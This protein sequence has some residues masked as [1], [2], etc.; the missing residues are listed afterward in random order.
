MNVLLIYTFLTTD[1][2]QGVYIKNLEGGSIMVNMEDFTPALMKPTVQ[3]NTEVIQ[4]I[5]SEAWQMVGS[6]RCWENTEE[7]Q[8]AQSW[9][10]TKFL[11]SND[12]KA[13][14]QKTFRS[15][16]TFACFL[17]METGEWIVAGL[18]KGREIHAKT[19]TAWLLMTEREKISNLEW[20]VDSKD[21]AK[22]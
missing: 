22:R 8:L 18:G 13:E 10:A 19:V 12:I 1:D 14:T 20:L 5:E 16:Y 3:W 15:L 7:G 21:E 17:G 11:W 4:N 2:L 6:T 9:W